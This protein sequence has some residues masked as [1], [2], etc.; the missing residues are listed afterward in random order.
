MYGALTFRLKQELWSMMIVKGVLET[1]ARLLE[2]EAPNMPGDIQNAF[3]GLQEGI[4]RAIAGLE[5]EIRKASEQLNLLKTQER[6]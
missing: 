4:C 3:S 6:R 1:L 2:C 5:Q